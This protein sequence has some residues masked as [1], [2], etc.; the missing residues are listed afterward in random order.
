MTEE[1]QN[2]SRQ[3]AYFSCA[4]DSRTPS[5][6]YEILFKKEDIHYVKTVIDKLEENRLHARVFGSVCRAKKQYR[7]IDMFG[8]GRSRDVQKISE[9]FRYYLENARE[10]SIDNSV[11]TH[12]PTGYRVLVNPPLVEVGKKAHHHL[13]LDRLVLTRKSVNPEQAS[14]DL[15]LIS[16]GNF[17]K[18]KG[19]QETAY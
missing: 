18:L 12:N 9:A 11:R 14:I 5:I 15:C 19:K 13:V 7:D 16:N 2:S 4:L 8:I 6:F 17:N 10:L 1:T 3:E